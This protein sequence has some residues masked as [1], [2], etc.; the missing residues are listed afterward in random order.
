MRKLTRYEKLIANGDLVQKKP[1]ITEPVVSV[2]EPEEQ[3]QSGADESLANPDVNK[4]EGLIRAGDT[5]N[6]EQSKK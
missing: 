6:E 4:L 5:G 1:R 2:Q 3:E